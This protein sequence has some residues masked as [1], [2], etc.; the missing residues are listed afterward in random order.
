MILAILIEL[1]LVTLK[2][3]DIEFNNNLL[4]HSSE[5]HGIFFVVVGR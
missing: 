1:K 4:I 2:H 3:M 5:L